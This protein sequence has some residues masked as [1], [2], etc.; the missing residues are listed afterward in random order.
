MK[1]YFMPVKFPLWLANY[2]KKRYFA[3]VEKEKCPSDFLL[4]IYTN[5]IIWLM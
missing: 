5:N 3:L 1:T 4:E 2:P